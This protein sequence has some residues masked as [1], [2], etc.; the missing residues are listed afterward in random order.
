MSVCIITALEAEILTEVIV[1]VPL[2]PNSA[3][4]MVTVYFVAVGLPVKLKP[5]V[6]H[7]PKAPSPDVVTFATEVSEAGMA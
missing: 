4:S 3:L 5:V 6:P 7:T 1:K 2:T